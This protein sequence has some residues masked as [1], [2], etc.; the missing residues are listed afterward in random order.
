MFGA[1]SRYF[2]ALGYMLTGRLDR[3]RESLNGDPDTI[4]ATY[5]RVI[6]EKTKRIH[7]YKDAV[8]AM[9]TQEERKKTSLKKLSEDIARLEKLREG[10]AAMAKKVVARHNGDIEAVKKDPEYVRC[11][12][13]FKDFSSTLDSK[14]E[15]AT[16]LDQEI[17][18]LSNNVESHK[19]QLEQLLRDLESVNREKHT[20]VAEVITAKEENEIADMLS[21]INND[22]TSEELQGLR[23]LRDRA[24]AS[25]R[26]SRELAG[27]DLARSEAEFLEYA[28]KSVANDE[29]DVLIGLSKEA[30]GN[31]GDNDAGTRTQIPE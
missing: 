12:A 4:R 24:K 16:E 25:A 11:Q 15:R 19:V 29:F 14:Q 10:A 22:R 2:R 17:Q 31:A 7:Q 28:E 1:I 30:E 18:E 13:S 9:M 8:G 6:Q 27:T 5:D 3:A 21:G 23:D 26:I 20:T